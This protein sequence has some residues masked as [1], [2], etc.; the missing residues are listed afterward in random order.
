MVPTSDVFILAG[1][2]GSRMGEQTDRIPKPM[3]SIGGKPIIEHIM[4]NYTRFLGK[5]R[6]VVLA[7]YRYDILQDYFKNEPDVVVIDTGEETQTGG[8]IGR[9]L[10]A[11]GW[12]SESFHVCYGDGLTNFDLSQLR[13][14]SDEAVNML[15]VHPIGRFGDVRFN[16]KGR[17]TNFS[18][19][20]VD[21]RW[22]NGGFFIMRPEVLDYI[23]GD[24]DVLETDVFSRLM[25][26]NKLYCTPYE[27][28]WHCMDTPKDWKELDTEYKIGEAKWLK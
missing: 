9:I 12:L 25:M 19:K 20:P 26:E 13:F 15:T 14:R 16:R 22:I 28:Y 8:R 4:Y 21:D 2:R 1:G 11:A 24:D 7:G 5:C 17:V 10:E 18:E 6:F 23:A 3:V 27:G